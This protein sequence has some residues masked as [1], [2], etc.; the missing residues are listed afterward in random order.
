M[1]Q[2]TGSR[3]LYVRR[4]KRMTAAQA[5]GYSNRDQ[6]SLALAEVPQLFEQSENQVFIEIG[7]GDGSV[8][9]AVALE[10]PTWICIGI[11]VYQP[12]IGALVHRCE[13][14]SPQNLYIVEEEAIAV[15]ELVPEHR[16]HQLY[17]LFPDPWPKRR[18]HFRRLIDGDFAALA[19]R[20]LTTSGSILVMTDHDD[21]AQQIQQVMSRSFHCEQ[22]ELDVYLPKTRYEMKGVEAGKTVWKYRFSLNN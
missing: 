16:I 10:N 5:R 6:Y 17:I 2:K 15:L 18:H 12:G 9:S 14:I 22:A 4:S 1:N 3:Q 8:L 20:K 7:F 13:R 19:E 21:Y 11:E